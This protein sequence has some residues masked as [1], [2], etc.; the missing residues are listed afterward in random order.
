M[1]TVAIVTAGVTPVDRV[2]RAMKLTRVLSF[3]R[4]PAVY[5]WDLFLQNSAE[6]LAHRASVL[7]GVAGMTINITGL[8]SSFLALPPETAHNTW[9]G[10]PY[11]SGGGGEVVELGQR[12]VIQS[13]AN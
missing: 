7:R 12:E 10:R 13:M 4:S 8:F 5:P 2:I 9:F 11:K 1:H 6:C 3:P